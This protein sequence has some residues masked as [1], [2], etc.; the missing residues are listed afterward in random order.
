MTLVSFVPIGL[1]FTTA[2]FPGEALDYAGKKQWIPPNPL[3]ALLGA[4][5]EKNEPVWTSFHDLLFNG[6]IDNVTRRRKSLFS[7]T[8]VLPWF[9]A[10]EATKIA[11]HKTLDS[12]KHTLVLRGRYLESAD[13]NYAD[14]RKVDLTGAQLEYA[15]FIETSLQGASL[16]K[17]QLQG[18]SLIGA[19]LQ[20]ARLDDAQ[21]QSAWLDD[22]QLQGASLGKAQLQGARFLKSTFVGTNI[23]YVA[24]WRTSFKDASLTAAL[25][26]GVKES[27]LTKSEFAD[28]KAMIMKEMPEGEKRD[29]ALKRIEILNPDSFGPEASE[30]ET[31]EKGRVDETTYKKSLAAQLKSIACSG[32]ESAPYIVRGLVTNGR[33]K[34]TGA[35]APG[36]VEAIVSP[37]VAH[38]CPVSAALT[39][40]DKVAR[41]S[42]PERPGG[43]H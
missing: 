16:G 43:A 2:T 17:V 30:Q 26:D 20:G 12:V 33:I 8:L 14:F 22:A 35:Q 3:T 36:L 32:D 28:L 27:A 39:E 31:L 13:F 15:W 5:N 21:L 24:V 1:A 19:Q 9:D 37:K 42:R 25:E 38:D 11:D 18:A 40:A 41:K 23:R 29:N 34:D 7:S 10:L 4:T 6:Q